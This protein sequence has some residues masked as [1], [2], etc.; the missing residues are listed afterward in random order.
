LSA[1]FQYQRDYDTVKKAERVEKSTM[2]E[3]LNPERTEHVNKFVN[4]V[5]KSRMEELKK[6]AAA[7]IPC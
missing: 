5:R 1:I 4:S 2:S 6:M 3:K 7:E